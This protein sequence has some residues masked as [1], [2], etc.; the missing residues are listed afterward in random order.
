MKR[1]IFR[2]LVALAFMV[3]S[4]A[5]YAK[6]FA[7]AINSDPEDAEVYVNG[8]LVSNTTPTII[9][10]DKKTASKTMIIQVRKDGYESKSATVSY[11]VKQL[12]ANPVLFLK[13]K[14]KAPEA[15]KRMAQDPTVTVGE[16]QQRV[17]RHN[18]GMTA[19]EQAIIR[20]YFDS[21][22]R[23]ARI[24]WR[25]ISSIPNEVKNTN[26]TYLTTTPLEE[27]RSFNI[28]GLTYDNSR[29]VTIEI[30]VSKRGYEDQVKRFNVRQ[31]LDQQEISGFFELVPKEVTE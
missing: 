15:S 16:S 2:L 5:T 13:M 3:T 20:W 19:M 7:I 21:D 4:L 10:V 29:D 18:A 28:Q 1:N 12:K 17:D 24:Y 14:K 25:V 23:G 8:Q 30:K 9:S 31:A 6:D 11:T 22:P 27:T 26:E